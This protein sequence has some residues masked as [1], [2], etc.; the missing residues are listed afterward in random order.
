M[1]LDELR[2][3]IR[4]ET[5]KSETI[6]TDARCL[7]FVRATLERMS[8]AHDWQGQGT[9]VVLTYTSTADGLDL[10]DDF[11]SEKHVSQRVTTSDPSQALLPLDKLNGGRQAW[12]DS[13]GKANTAARALPRTNAVD[14]LFYYL[15]DEKLFVVPNPSGDTSLVLDYI[16]SPAL[17]A[18]DAIASNFLTRRYGRTV[19]LA[20]AVR[21]AY[22]F[23]R[24]WDA[25]SQMEAVYQGF[26]D[27]ALKRDMSTRL[28]GP[29]PVRG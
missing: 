28:S 14:R 7:R 27:G 6:L 18:D 15:W 10:P 25:A 13:F 2:D 5:D 22:R 12:L 20:G 3:A 21:E 8:N 9:S 29:K 1:T 19:V 16:A 23:L 4:D 24:M 17:L 26:L 11:I